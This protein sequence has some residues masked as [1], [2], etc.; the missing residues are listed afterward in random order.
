MFSVFYRTWPCDGNLEKTLVN[1]QLKV[2]LIRDSIFF[3]AVFSYNIRINYGFFH[4]F[5]NKWYSHDFIGK[6]LNYKPI[7]DNPIHALL[8]MSKFY[9]NDVVDT[10]DIGVALDFSNTWHSC[11]YLTNNNSLMWDFP[12]NIFTKIQ[13]SFILLIYSGFFSP[14]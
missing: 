8:L 13:F 7:H 12:K 4:F 1:Q 3:G 5:L 10:I 2:L 14:N 6:Y 11:F 9:R